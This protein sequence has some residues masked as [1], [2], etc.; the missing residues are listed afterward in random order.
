M[1]LNISFNRDKIHS[2]ATMEIYTK[3]AI[4]INVW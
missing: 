1:E 4:F 2:V 3:L